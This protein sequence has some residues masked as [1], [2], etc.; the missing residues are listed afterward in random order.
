MT[1]IAGTYLTVLV[2]VFQLNALL[3]AVIA[4]N[5]ATVAAVVPP[6]DQRKRIPTFLAGS[7]GFI[8]HP[9][10]CILGL[11]LGLPSLVER[12]D[13]PLDRIVPFCFLRLG[14]ETDDK[15]FGGGLHNKRITL[16]VHALAG[17]NIAFGQ[18]DLSIENIQT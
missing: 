17:I 4:D 9:Q 12:H 3:A 1:G 18:L 13:R 2:D 10:W 15:G 16:F 14:G 11:L 8:W 6:I 5:G 7:R